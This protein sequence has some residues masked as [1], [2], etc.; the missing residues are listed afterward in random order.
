MIDKSKKDKRAGVIGSTIFHAVILILL[1][2]LGL[3]SIPREEE[4]ILVDFGD[5][6]TGWGASE[7]VRNNPTGERNTPPPVSQPEPVS[8]PPASTPETSEEAVN[9]QDFE[10]APTISEEEKAKQEA[11]KR[12]LE[13][14]RQRQ[15][16][17][18]RQKRIEEER[19]RQ[20]ELERQRQLE[21][22]RRQQEEQE[23]QAQEARSNVSNAFS[24]SDGSSTSQGEAGGSGNQGALG[25]EAGVGTYNGSGKGGSGTGFDLSGRTLS[26]ALPKPEYNI[27]EEGI[28][29]V[30][31][32]VDRNGNVVSA[33]PIL[34]GTTTQNS[35]LWRVARQAALKAKFNSKGDAPAYQKGTITYH[36]NL[37]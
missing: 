11:E 5:S 6:D 9:T 34:K 26:G 1:L 28:V 14:E 25:G 10:E 22:E 30:E 29:V 31:I 7:P 36:F 15:V 23:R 3:S 19:Q 12:R 18:N 2:V 33:E 21:E 17:I 16:E 13:E 27:Q 20:E 4:G 37:N 32:T 8:P 35:Y 24:K